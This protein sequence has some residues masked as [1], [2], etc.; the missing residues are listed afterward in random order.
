MY[1]T[2]Q[3]ARYLMILPE[4]VSSLHFRFLD[5]RQEHNRLKKIK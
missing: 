3:I 4:I 1:N 2:L 5:H